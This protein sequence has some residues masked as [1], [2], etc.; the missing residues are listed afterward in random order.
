MKGPFG[1]AFYRLVPCNGQDHDLLDRRMDG[2]GFCRKEFNT[3]ETS[4][5]WTEGR[6]SRT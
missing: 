6:S 1:R 4:L 3:R 2:I 5:E